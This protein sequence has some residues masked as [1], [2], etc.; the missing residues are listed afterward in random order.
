MTPVRLTWVG[1]DHDFALTIGNLRALQ[2][3][4]NAGP[5]EVFERVMARKWR[6]DDLFETLRQGLIGG[7][8]DQ[9]KASDM[10]NGAMGRHPLLE[11]V[12]TV[13]AVLAHSL[14]GPEDD[15]VGEPEGATPP[16][17]NGGSASSTAAAQ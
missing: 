13:Q 16:P 2:Q 15:K 8:M 3:H 6:V 9:A 4:C 7:G 11:F 1:G 12:P 10:V 5:H 14:V 17:E